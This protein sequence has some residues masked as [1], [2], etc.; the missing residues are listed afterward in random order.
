[1]D[2]AF[3]GSLARGRVSAVA[4]GDTDALKVADITII[5]ATPPVAQP[6]A[7]GRA[8]GRERG[9]GAAAGTADRCT[10]RRYSDGSS[11]TFLQQTSLFL[12]LRRPLSADSSAF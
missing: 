1:M 5:Q 8:E 7:A 11:S 9:R 3:V 10:Q 4:A 2:A 12:L 6:I